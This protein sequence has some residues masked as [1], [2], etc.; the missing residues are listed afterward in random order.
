MGKKNNFL[1]IAVLILGMMSLAACGAEEIAASDSS[2]NSAGQER[3]EGEKGG[4][5][6]V[7]LEESEQEYEAEDGTLLLTAKR[8]LPTVVISANEEGA[9]AINEYIKS[10]ALLDE[11]AML[12]WA[13]EAYSSLGK[14][15]WR[16][17]SLD[18]QYFTERAD[19]EAISFHVTSYSDM[20]GAH[21]NSAS[22]GLNFNPKTGKRLTLAEAALE[23]EAAVLAI[24][25]FLLAETKK[26][27]Y[28]GEFFEGY[29]ENVGDIL[30]EDTWYLGEDG[31]HITVNEYIISPHAAGMMDFVIPYGEAD[32]LKEEFRM[33][34]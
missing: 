25:E 23:E 4:N 33:N 16:K 22:I 15:N 6:Y 14:E 27:E 34:R 20:G 21:P 29:E 8:S 30:T 1:F 19:E 28:R 24:N 13:K 26:E 32:F 2:E 9:A 7:M 31:L 12:E 10:Q 11:E 3:E 5:I 17:F 18:T